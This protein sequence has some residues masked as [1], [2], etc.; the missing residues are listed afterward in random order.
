MV[1]VVPAPAVNSIIPPNIFKFHIYILHSKFLW[2]IPTIGMEKVRR[3]SKKILFP[4]K[5]HMHAFSSP[6]CLKY[7]KEKDD[8]GKRP[9]FRG[10]AFLDDR[11]FLA[12]IDLF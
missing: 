6:S 8:K 10:V 1:R 4:L 12:H 2:A 7:E 11:L 5:H 9:C 3:E